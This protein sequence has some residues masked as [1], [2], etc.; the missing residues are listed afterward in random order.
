MHKSKHMVSVTLTEE[1]Y[2]AL[3]QVAEADSIRVSAAVQQSVSSLLRALR[4]GEISEDFIKSVMLRH[5]KHPRK[6]SARE[7]TQGGTQGTGSGE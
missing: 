4:N 1:Q 3:L 2:N 6:P 5:R 7:A